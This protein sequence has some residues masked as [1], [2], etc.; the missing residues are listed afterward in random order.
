VGLLLDCLGL[1]GGDEAVLSRTL[2]LLLA[3]GARAAVE[4]GPARGCLCSLSQR[5]SSSSSAPSSLH[6]F[7]WLARGLFLECE[8]A[9]EEPVEED[10][11]LREDGPLLPETFSSAKAGVLQPP[12]R[13]L[14]WLVILIIDTL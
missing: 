7:S 14:K 1:S 5:K 3:V 9:N 13:R 11:V 4:V 2:V 12:L 8:K 10:E 6:R